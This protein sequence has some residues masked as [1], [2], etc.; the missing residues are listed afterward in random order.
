M[1]TASG[2]MPAAATV[3]TKPTTAATT[4]AQCRGGSG[5]RSH[6]STQPAATNTYR[7][8]PIASTHQPDSRATYTLSTM[9]RNASTSMSKRAPNAEVVSVRRAT[10]PSTPS[11]TSATVESATRIA[12]RRLA[13]ERVHRERRDPTG[14][15]GAGQRHPVRRPQSDLAVTR[16]RASK[17]GGKAGSAG[18]TGQPAG[19][20][21]AGGRRE[22]TEEREQADEAGERAGRD[23]AAHLTQPDAPCLRIS[24]V[25]TV[26]R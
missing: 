12:D 20:V 19:R 22:D 15:D 5:P 11:S 9:I 18:D 10:R 21:E 8:R 26:I 25:R 24:G 7:A 23:P 6:G 16:Q 17:Q 1:V 2:R 14:E 4:L 3:S 13:L